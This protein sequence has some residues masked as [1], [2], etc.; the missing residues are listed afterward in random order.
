MIDKPHC[1]RFNDLPEHVKVFLENLRIDDV[2][3]IEEG[4]KLSKAAR[5]VGKFW[6]WVALAVVSTFAGVV[7]VIT[8]IKTIG[9]WMRGG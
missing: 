5:T 6:K 1:E 8:S 7:T 9:E 3:A 4:I 2:A